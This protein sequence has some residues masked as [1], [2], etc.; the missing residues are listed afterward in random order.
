MSSSDFSGSTFI[1]RCLS[2]IMTRPWRTALEF[3]AAHF[4][5]AGL[6]ASKVRRYPAGAAMTASRKPSRETLPIGRLRAEGQQGSTVS[7]W[8]RLKGNDPVYAG[9]VDHASINHRP[10]VAGAA[11]TLIRKTQPAPRRSRI[12]AIWVEP[13]CNSVATYC[14]IAAKLAPPPSYRPNVIV[15]KSS[16]N[17]VGSRCAQMPSRN[18]DGH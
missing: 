8:T 16:G 5:R 3:L 11:E 18:L 17:R 7:I 6:V 12:A 14:C 4:F 9:K 13:S 15:A 2:M 1:G 10:R